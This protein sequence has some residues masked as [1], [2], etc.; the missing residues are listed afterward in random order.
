MEFS[1]SCSFGEFCT[2][3]FLLRLCGL[4]S[5]DLNHRVNVLLKCDLN[6]EL[7]IVELTGVW[8]GAF[9]VWLYLHGATWHSL[10]NHR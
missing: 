3:V 10:L 8:G 6:G 2:S 9:N 1:L 4:P 7:T 5:C